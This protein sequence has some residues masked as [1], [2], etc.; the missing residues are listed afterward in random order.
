MFII[1]VQLEEANRFDT[2]FYINV[3]LAIGCCFVIL[4]PTTY[5]FFSLLQYM[6]FFPAE[7]AAVEFESNF[8]FPLTCPHDVPLAMRYA[9]E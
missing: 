6:H 8:Q 9:I 7:E 2:Y 1:L 3:Q 5:F 4:Y